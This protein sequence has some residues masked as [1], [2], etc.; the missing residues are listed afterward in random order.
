MSVRQGMLAI[1]SQG[2][3]HG[4]QLK[5][6]FEA[7]TGGT[8]PLN[9]G[10]A[11]TTLSR[12]QRDG[13]V[14]ALP[15]EEGAPERFA[16]TDAGRDEVTAWW[17]EPVRRDTP[18]RDELAIKLALAVTVPGV[19]VRA[20]VQMQRTESLRALR[21]FTRLKSRPRRTGD[22]APAPR[23]G[24]ARA[25]QQD[26]AAALQALTAARE[27]GSPQAELAW[28]LVL[29]SLIFGM[30]AETRWLDHVEA[31]VA[32]AAEGRPT[33]TSTTSTTPPLPAHVTRGT[34]APGAAR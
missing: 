11:Y 1:L 29:D 30:E 4:Y 34:T 7:R 13:L 21:D 6:E 5:Q 12:L 9:I 14:D 27:A 19:D 20:I 24:K 10:Q 8:W 31:R 18:A 28:S 2:P 15:V 32:R 23:T 16:L 33:T 26:E 22:T 25:Q 3:M 17:T